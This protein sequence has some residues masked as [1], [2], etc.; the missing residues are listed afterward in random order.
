M[1]N[2]T[3]TLVR[4]AHIPDLG[5]RRGSLITSKNGRIKPE[6]MMVNGVEVHAPNGRYELRYYVGKKPVWKNAGA[7][8]DATLEVL[9]LAQRKQKAENLNAELGIKA[10]GLTLAKAGNRETLGQ[11]KT[12]F[13]EK[14]AVGR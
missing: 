2:R 12:S 6:W 4:Y 1:A 11:L 10:E 8:L 9:D 14:Y 3:I 5:W 7:D 13:L